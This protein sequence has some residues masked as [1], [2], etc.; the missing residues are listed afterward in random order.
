MYADDIALVLALAFRHKELSPTEIVF[1]S[2]LG[3]L[4]RYFVDWRL[5]ANPSK[6]ECYTF[7]F[8]SK[9]ANNNLC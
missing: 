4:C 7:H 8:N 2:D 5:R 1:S 9:L 6:T 3:I